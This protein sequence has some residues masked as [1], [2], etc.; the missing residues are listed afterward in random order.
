[1]DGAN[2]TGVELGNTDFSGANL[3]KAILSLKENQI[4]DPIPFTLTNAN[5]VGADLDRIIMP[6]G[7]VDL[8]GVN[9]AGANLRRAHLTSQTLTDL[10]NCDL[11]KS[12]SL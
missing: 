10:A 6:N 3:N 9:L 11:E 1:M 5:L 4:A 7:R 12:R 8:T 2:L